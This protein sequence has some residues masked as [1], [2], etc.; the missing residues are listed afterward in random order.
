MGLPT[1]SINWGCAER[2]RDSFGEGGRML[3][4]PLKP[5]VLGVTGYNRAETDS[6]P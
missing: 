1:L 6:W 2:D 4:S 5:F 3:S